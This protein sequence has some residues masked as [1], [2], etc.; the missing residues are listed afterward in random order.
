[1]NLQKL[2]IQLAAGILCLLFSAVVMAQVKTETSTTKE[3]STVE[4]TVERGEVVA[5]S[6]ND[7]VVKMEDGQIRNFPN[8]PESARVSVGGK[9]LSVHELQPGMKLERTITTTATPQVVTTVKSVTGRVW[10]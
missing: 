3:Q 6:G 5:V 8:I 9:E 10:H 2:R 1:M 7:L 4:T